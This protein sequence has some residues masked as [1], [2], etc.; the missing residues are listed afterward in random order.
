[1]LNASLTPGT[2]EQLSTTAQFAD[3]EAIAAGYG[4]AWVEGVGFR[5]MI[6]NASG[7]TQCTSSVVP[8]GTV[9]ANQQLAV[10]DSAIGNIVVAT[11]PDS[12]LIHLYR[13]DNSCKLMDDIDVSTTSTSPTEPRVVHGVSNVVIYWTDSTGG[14]YRFLSDQLCH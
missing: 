14:R 7:A 2:A 1:M 10:S 12:N 13:F 4:I 9:P 6:K 5:F 8:F 3:L 11:S